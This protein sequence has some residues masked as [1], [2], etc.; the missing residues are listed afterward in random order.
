MN[1]L[2][3]GK[4]YLERLHNYAGKVQFFMVAWLF[5]RDPA[6]EWR[7][8]YWPLAGVGVLLLLWVDH[9][10]IVPAELKVCMDLNPGWQALLDKIQPVSAKEVLTLLTQACPRCQTLQGYTVLS[11]TREVLVACKS[12][13]A[14]QLWANGRW[15]ET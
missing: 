5:F 3:L 10:F 4:V 6:M 7:W 14:R 2:G 13:D 8:F 12:C 15:V 9:T 11:G 1:A